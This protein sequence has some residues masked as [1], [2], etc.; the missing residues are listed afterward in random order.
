MNGYQD[1]DGGAEEVKVFLYHDQLYVEPLTVY[2]YGQMVVDRRISDALW[3]MHF[4]KIS[5]IW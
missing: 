1:W 2:L 4:Q 5:K 3:M